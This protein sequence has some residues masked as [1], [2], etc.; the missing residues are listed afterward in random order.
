[1]SIARA[2]EFNRTGDFA[3]SKH[4]VFLDNGSVDDT[5]ARA[6]HYSNVTLLRTKYKPEN[7]KPVMKKYLS[8]RFAKNK[9]YIFLE[10]DELVEFSNQKPKVEPLSKLD[11][12]KRI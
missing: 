7:Y 9:P 5:I 12:I 10:V 2:V 1:M 11:L 4:I 6:S 8:E 3:H